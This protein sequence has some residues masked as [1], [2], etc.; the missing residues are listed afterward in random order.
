MRI[1]NSKAYF[2]YNIIEKF[3]CGIVLNGCEVKS[4]RAGKASIKNAY[5]SYQDPHIMIHNMHIAEYDKVQVKDCD[6]MRSRIMLVHKK[7][8]N[9]MMAISKT[10]GSTIVP[11]ELFWNKRGFAKIVCAIVTGKTL[12][13]KRASIKEKEWNRSKQAILKNKQQLN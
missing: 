6:T 1:V 2:D 8:K 4:I 5:V 12:Y 9:K 7:E 11:L 3:E 10:S 13:D